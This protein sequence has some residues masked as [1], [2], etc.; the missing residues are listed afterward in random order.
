MVEPLTR[1]RLQP[2]LL[3]RLIDDAPTSMQEPLEMRALTRKQLRESVLRDLS[4]LFNAIRQEPMARQSAD[5]S[6]EMAARHVAA[7]S[8]WRRAPEAR[9]SVL[10]FGMPGFSGS[11]L[12]AIGL[13]GIEDS[14][15]AAI[16]AFEPRILPDSL[17]VEA[18]MLND[19][20]P[21]ALRMTIRGLLWGQPVPL[22]LLLSADI[23]CETGSHRLRDLRS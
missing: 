22:E 9:T 2:A 8:A 14:V 19:G 11:P 3:D 23:D 17:Q 1:D 18:A 16:L 20:Q 6:E 13:R 7:I 21:N 5:V 4:W 12:S 15:H 10:N